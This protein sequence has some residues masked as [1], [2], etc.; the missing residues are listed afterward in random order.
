MPITSDYPASATPGVFVH[1][2]ALHGLASGHRFTDRPAASLLLAA[3]V[4]AV[5]WFGST[6]WVRA[7]SLSGAGVVVTIGL[8]IAGLALGVD[9]PVG[10]VTLAMILCAAARL[11]F[12][13][14]SELVARRRLRQ[15]FAG[16]VSPA[17]MRELEAGRLEGLSSRRRHLCV[18]FLD[19]R[20]FTK[21][22]E[23]ESPEVVL[24]MLRL[25]FETVTR[26]VHRRGGTVKEF[27]GDGVMALFGAPAWLDNPEQAAFDAARAT[28]AEL[29]DVNRSLATSLHAPI[30]IGIGL[31]SG[32]AVVGNIGA[33]TR[34]AYGA[35]GDCVNLASRLEGLTKTLGCPILMSAQ[36]ASRLAD[37][38]A[39]ADLGIQPIAGH[40]AVPVFGWKHDDRYPAT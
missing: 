11:S 16:Y 21:R 22:T 5:L 24:R 15:A 32:E 14:G 13:V 20:G 19:I 28:L 17:V 1:A 3:I 27:M 40:D 36:V 25:L 30:A 6:T 31:A 23:A 26:V 7:L 34:Y 12:E 33:S 29:V 38:D 39:L 35:V 4:C 37:R 2:Q 8:A 9:M 10:N 18:M